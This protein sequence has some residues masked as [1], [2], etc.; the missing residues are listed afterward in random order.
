M[1]KSYS[2]IYGPIESQPTY[3]VQLE[4]FPDVKLFFRTCRLQ[5]FRK[6]LLMH[7]VLFNCTDLYVKL[8]KFPFHPI[9]YIFQE[10]IVSLL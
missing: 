7:V 4:N 1:E 6:G 5:L 2:D 9:H 3:T 8:I 10:H